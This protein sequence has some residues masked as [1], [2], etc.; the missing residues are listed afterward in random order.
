MRQIREVLR[1]RYVSKLP[2]RAMADDTGGDYV[3]LAFEG[4]TT[5][6]AP[7]HGRASVRISG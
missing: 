7:R 2:Q 1:L 3:A 5:P 4:R 6:R